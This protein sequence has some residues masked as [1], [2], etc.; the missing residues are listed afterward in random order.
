LKWKSTEIYIFS[1]NCRD[2]I[3]E[4]DISFFL[5]VHFVALKIAEDSDV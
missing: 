1:E 3:K 4:E 5:S 2:V